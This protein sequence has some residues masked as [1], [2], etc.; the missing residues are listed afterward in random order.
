MALIDGSV[1]VQE[2]DAQSSVLLE[3]H[4]VSTV[5]VEL[6]HLH[7]QPWLGSSV[8]FG[9]VLFSIWI[10]EY[11][12]MHIDELENRIVSELGAFELKWFLFVF[13]NIERWERFN[14]IFL[15]KSSLSFSNQPELQ[16]FL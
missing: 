15:G 7:G 14:L 13:D 8:W 12:R 11:L 5:C 2:D 16:C 4:I 9:F 6:R 3:T 10:N 1:L